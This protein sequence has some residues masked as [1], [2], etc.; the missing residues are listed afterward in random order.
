[1]DDTPQM[2]LVRMDDLTILDATVEP[3]LDALEAGVQCMTGD[4][5]LTLKAEYDAN[6]PAPKPKKKG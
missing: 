5:W 6:P 4:T 2:L 3:D 1:M